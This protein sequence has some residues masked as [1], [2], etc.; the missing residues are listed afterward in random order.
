MTNHLMPENLVRDN[1]ECPLHFQGETKR[2]TETRK[3]IIFCLGWLQR[4]LRASQ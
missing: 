4:V 2:S 1:L 3:T